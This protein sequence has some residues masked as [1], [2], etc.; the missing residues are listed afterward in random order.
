MLGP[1]TDAD[2]K[3]AKKAKVTAEPKKL[4]AAPVKAEAPTLGR[5]FMDIMGEAMNFHKPGTYQYL[6]L[7]FSVVVRLVSVS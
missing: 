3:P 5:S 1:K 4:A 6:Y 7:S 2:K